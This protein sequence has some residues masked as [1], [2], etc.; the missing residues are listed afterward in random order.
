M[1]YVSLLL[2]LASGDGSAAAAGAPDAGSTESASVQK[3]V[4]I[5][6]ES[7]RASLAVGLARQLAAKLG[8]RYSTRGMI[9][10]GAGR[11]RWPT[12]WPDT[13]YAGSYFLRRMDED[14]GDPQKNDQ[15]PNALGSC[16]TV[17][18]A[19]SYG[20]PGK[21]FVIVAGVVGDEDAAA[22]LPLFRQKMQAVRDHV[23][24]IYM[25]CIH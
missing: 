2:L 6:G 20:L 12:N 18:K 1:M 24:S 22:R 23:T 7:P 14:C 17:E 25:G 4:L 10:D 15:T 5:L 3:H 9:V 13:I 8:L 11:L 16:I 19:D 21:G